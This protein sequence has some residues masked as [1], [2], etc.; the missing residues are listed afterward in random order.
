[1]AMKPGHGGGGN[2]ERD[3]RLDLL[4]RNTPRETPPPHLDAAI[5]AAARRE[6]GARPRP[7][8]RPLHRW[9]L[10]VSIAAVVVLSVTLVTLVGEESR[11]PFMT[12]LRST[13][14]PPAARTVEPQIQPAEPARPADD[15]QRAPVAASE[16]FSSRRDEGAA[17]ALP[18]PG[19]MEQ[20][21]RSDAG[22]AATPGTPATTAPEADS[23]ISSGTLQDAPR[24]AA[25]RPAGKL[26]APDE[27]REPPPAGA[28]RRSSPERAAPA[29][30]QAKPMSRGLQA[31]SALKRL[32]AW[33]GLE[34]EQP[35][36]W[37][38]RL[39]ELRRQKHT[40]D[41]DE[42][43]AEFKRRFPDHPLPSGLE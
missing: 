37:L 8:F 2:G 39:A 15:R 7:L 18:E 34:Q 20:R 17:K 23:R 33:H 31:E 13:A 40:A 22:P 36:K 21:A 42:L 29:A 26:A 32:P 43:L 12:E 27:R 10:P 38:E 5:L 41:A 3:P 11:D 35:R 14:E 28:A 24:A 30:P 4:Y 16:P 9:R 19:M 1:M 6:A 25:E